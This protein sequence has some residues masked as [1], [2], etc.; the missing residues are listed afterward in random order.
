[1]A[2]VKD[3][4]D[5]IIL[6]LNNE[7]K[8][9]SIDLYEKILCDLNTKYH[10]HIFDLASKKRPLKPKTGFQLFCIDYK[11]NVKTELMEN[12]CDASFKSI[13]SLLS[14]RWKIMKDM[15]D[16]DY[17]KYTEIHK[18][19][20]QKYYDLY[21]E[22]KPQQ[23]VKKNEKCHAPLYKNPFEF[24]KDD[25]MKNGITSLKSI[26]QEWKNLKLDEKKYNRYKKLAFV[27]KETK[28]IDQFIDGKLDKL[29]IQGNKTTFS[30][31]Y[32]DVKNDTINELNNKNIKISSDELYKIIREKWKELKNSNDDNDKSKILMYKKIREDHINQ[33]EM[34]YLIEQ[35][36]EFA[37]SD[38]NIGNIEE[39]N[40]IVNID[41]FPNLR[42]KAYIKYKEKRQ[43]EIK[44]V[45]SK[46]KISQ[47][48]NSEWE[49][50][51]INE[52]R[53]YL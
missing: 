49:N 38:R 22:F 53:K 26:S 24:F 25:M 16:L 47:I 32:E 19:N 7:I 45:S 52:R 4:K 5:L 8:H 27:D 44:D 28:R 3:I 33:N 12:E 1:M 31:F 14:Q 39:N 18:S 34:H 48:I 36:T 51:S 2:T 42:I 10:S 43:R 41:S 35:M 23:V 17:V 37:Q 21:P 6:I 50:M 13:N 20:I 30:F 15:N 11:Q 29:P 40:E 46:T 9:V